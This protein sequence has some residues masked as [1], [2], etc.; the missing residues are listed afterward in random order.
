MTFVGAPHDRPYVIV[1]IQFVILKYSDQLRCT[2]QPLRLVPGAR[3]RIGWFQSHR[4]NLA[5]NKYY[6]YFNFM[7]NIFAVGPALLYQR[8]LRLIARKLFQF[9]CHRKLGHHWQVR[10]KL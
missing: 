7:K 10:E 1:Q 2:V 8:F 3:A 6:Y 5:N 4:F 9:R